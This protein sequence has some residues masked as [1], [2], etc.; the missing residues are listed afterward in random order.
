LGI[1]R[2]IRLLHSP[3]LERALFFKGFLPFGPAPDVEPF[4]KVSTGSTRR[5]LVK[6]LTGLLFD[7]PH[8]PCLLE[9]RQKPGTKR[10]VTATYSLYPGSSLAKNISSSIANFENCQTIT[11]NNSISKIAGLMSNCPDIT[12]MNATY[13]SI[14]RRRAFQ[15]EPG[16]VPFRRPGG[17]RGLSLLKLRPPR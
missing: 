12:K 6:T 5:L 1:Q 15:P 14:F 16:L 4:D 3:A 13:G 11:Q 17:K 9:P 2:L 10:G 8:H 7:R